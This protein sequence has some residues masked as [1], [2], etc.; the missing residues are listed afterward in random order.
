[1]VRVAFTI[2]LTVAVAAVALPAVDYAGVQRSDTAARDA[3]DRLVAE[4][5][6]LAAGNDALPTDAKPAR[7][8]VTLHLPAGG[9]ASAAVETFEVGPPNATAVDRSAGAT[10]ATQFHWRVRGG[11]GHTVGVDGVRIRPTTGDRFRLAGGKTRL[12]L[13]LVATREGPVVRI[14]RQKLKY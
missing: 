12:V 13:R 10:E 3:V 4:A 11:T 6:A 1:M 5:R 7:R 8:T 14:G 9:F 2:A